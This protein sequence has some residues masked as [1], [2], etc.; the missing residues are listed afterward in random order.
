MDTTHYKKALY[1]TLMFALVIVSIAALSYAHS[2]SK[3][4]SPESGW[5]TI[6]VSG[7][8]K[9]TGIPDVA[10]VSFSV[11]TDAADAAKAQEDT[12]KKM[13]DIT[14]FLEEKG[15]DKKDI[16]TTGYNVYPKQ[17]YR[18]PTRVTCTMVTTG[19]SVSQEV[20]VKIRDMGKTG[21]ILG[22]VVSKGATGA[23]G[24]TFVIDDKSKLED[25]ARGEA[26]AKAKEKA[27]SI[28]RQS[29]LKLGKLIAISEDGSGYMPYAEGKG[30][31]AMDSFMMAPQANV[32]PN[33][34]P[35][36]QDV[37]MNVTL[38]YSIR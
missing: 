3:S 38:T 24:P 16:Q 30:G 23:S 5:N 10:E 9:A 1:G 29:G 33:I 11:T 37:T 36:S 32:A 2:Y 15:V 22:G 34:Q 4:F 18:C 12:V 35:G 17:E 13:D 25:E 27:E 19:Y 28:A 21:E 14:K 7:E 31:G 6:N 20:T 8:G 26:I